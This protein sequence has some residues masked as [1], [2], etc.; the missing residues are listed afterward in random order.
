M[1]NYC[2]FVNFVFQIF[3]LVVVF[4]L[5]H[6]LVF[7]PVSLSLIGPKHPTL[8]ESHGKD[9]E[10]SR[11]NDMNLEIKCSKSKSSEAEDK[12]QRQSMINHDL[13][14]KMSE[15]SDQYQNE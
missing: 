13:E 7:L 8:N 6:G 9:E 10:Q 4:A 14:N 12:E 5:F 2:N 3:F 1:Y 11:T 15:D